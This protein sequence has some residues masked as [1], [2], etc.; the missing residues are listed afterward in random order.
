MQNTLIKI[1]GI[2]DPDTAAQAAKLGANYIGLM[3]YKNSKRYV[4]LEQ[5]Q[6]I[7]PAIKNN[8]AE[9]VA[10]FVDANADVM[11]AICQT[12]G[13]SIVQLQGD[14]SR[15]EH[16]LL[17]TS[18]KRI[19]VCDVSQTGQAIISNEAAFNALDKTRDFLMFDSSKPGTGTAFSWNN[20][21]HQH[22]FPWFLAGGLN[23]NNVSEALEQLNPDGVDVSSGVEN[24]NARKD[25]RL[26][27]NFITAVRGLH[28]V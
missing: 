25:I 2:T 28:H 8:G 6:A 22:A 7:V 18:F 12:A 27:E 20:F 21:A 10:V 17:P 16:P 19:F 26:I 9:P 13:I 3:F 4:T 14:I 1:C 23:P 15:G 24:Q 11:L 5:A